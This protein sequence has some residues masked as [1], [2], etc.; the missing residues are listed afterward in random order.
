MTDIVEVRNRAIRGIGWS[1]LET[2][3]AQLLRFVVYVLLARLVGPSAF[4]IIA[5]AGV[6]LKL[7][8]IL[9]K[10]GFGEAIVQ[11]KDLEGS[12]IDAA[13]WLSFVGGIVFAVALALAAPYISRFYAEEELSSVIRW[14]SLSFVISGISGIPEAILLRKMEFRVLALRS[15]FAICSGGAAGL[16]LACLGFGVWSLVVQ[17]L[18]NVLISLLMLW[19]STSWRPKFRFSFSHAKQLCGFGLKVTGNN[20]LWCICKRFDQALVGYLFGS[21]ALGAYSL[22]GRTSQMLSDFIVSPMG[23]I[24]LPSF[25]RMQDMPDMLRAEFYRWTKIISIFCLPAFAGM[26]A[27]AP[28]IVVVGFGAKW[29][30]VVP[31]LRA[32]CV[33]AAIG[34]ALG[35][36]HAL[37]LSLGRPG[38]YLMQ[39]VQL[40]AFT[41]IG[42][43]IAS[44]WSAVAVAWALPV[45][46]LVHITI[47][48]PVLRS[49]SGISINRVF[50]AV[51]RPGIP[52]F[53]MA[54]IVWFSMKY[55]PASLLGLFR[56]TIGIAIG[57][58]TYLFLILLFC[59]E[60]IQK[61][62]NILKNF[63]RSKKR[64]QEECFL[65]KMD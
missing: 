61:T 56:M 57:V 7:T 58:V 33:Y 45:A 1:S 36:T 50:F 4:G 10:Q 63:I 49:V 32:F 65:E 47:Y 2:W 43:L 16:I 62:R 26:F 39:F 42:C 13:F 17:Q 21:F 22:A 20:L 23:R 3:G 35:L 40:T 60:I 11:R 59:P 5:L 44:R 48:I 15:L 46:M 34:T 52:A 27:L 18:T 54:I 51:I 41:M 38:V 31:F 12:H 14:L 9:V 6:F 30:S 8:E 55:I 19:F 29:I 64:S 37:F 25:S 28:D 24:A 53:V